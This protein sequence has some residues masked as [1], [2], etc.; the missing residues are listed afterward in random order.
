MI[1]TH[2]ALRWFRGYQTLDLAFEKGLTVIEGANGSGKTNL[3][4][5]LYYLSLAKSWRTSDTR[6]LIRY[7]EDEAYI[8]ASVRKNDIGHEIE[9]HITPL[10]RKIAIDGKPVRRLSELS[11]LANVILFSPED[12]AIFKG[13][14][15]GRRNFLDVSLS[16]QS[17]DYFTLIG[18]YNHLLDERN[19]ALKRENPDKTYLEV[20]TE[21][22]IEVEEPL[23]SHRAVYVAEL[24][25]NLGLLVS[26]LYGESRNL[27]IEYR[28]FVKSPN[29]KEAAKK[30]YAKSLD[31]DIYRKVTGIGIHREDFTGILDG[32][33]IAAYGS[34]GENRLA[35][36]ALKLSPYFLI[37]DIENKPIAVLDD[38]YSELDAEHRQRL[39]AL[40]G[41]LGQCFVTA[42]D[43]NP[44]EGASIIEVASNIATRRK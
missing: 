21:Q 33:D 35:G 20:L 34:Q 9:I 3:A 12:A 7:G 28:P 4:E 39:N 30:A 10:G 6:S 8:G 23:E 13:S 1:L 11:R 37:E 43:T 24:N 2:L 41:K 29:W 22:M 31:S 32:K 19:L 26:E 5:A 42:T 16:K 15:G 40:L 17:L 14:P 44:N 25:K 18:R 38:V 27:S 36:I